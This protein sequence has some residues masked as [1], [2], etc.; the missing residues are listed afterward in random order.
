M[1]DLAGGAIG[2]Y[3]SRQRRLRGISLDDLAES[4]KIPRRSLERLEAG[5]F[6]G[7]S[8]GF[9]RGFVRTI[10]DAL[11]LDSKDSINRLLGEPPASDHEIANQRSRNYRWLA[12]AA[13]AP[14]AIGMILAA[15]WVWERIDR[16]AGSLDEPTI[17]YRRDAV[18]ALALEQAQQSSQHPHPLS[19][20]PSTHLSDYPSKPAKPVVRGKSASEQLE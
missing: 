12:I 10:A 3:L 9:S 6:D 11:G 13:A 15:V 20:P 5:A 14:I 19:N 7:Q 2:A 18:R 16:F 8:D 4:T 1:T 17:V